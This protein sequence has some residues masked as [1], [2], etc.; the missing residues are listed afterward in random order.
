MTKTKD[1]APDSDNQPPP[2]VWAS[3][4]NRLPTPIAAVDDERKRIVKGIRALRKK[5]I[6]HNW[7][8]SVLEAVDEILKVVNN[9]QRDE[10][11]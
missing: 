3:I 7:P 6:A 11:F 8:A 5:Y 10:E 1:D 2:R 9:K 4:G